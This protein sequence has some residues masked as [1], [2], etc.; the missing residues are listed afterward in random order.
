MPERQPVRD[1]GRPREFDL[2]LVLHRAI[3]VFRQ[4]GY[5][6]TSIADL[7]E[8]MALSRGSLYKAFGDKK[9]VFTAAYDLY[10]SEG[11]A[12]LEA[13]ARDLG[14]GRDRIAA[15]LA[16]YARLSQGTEGLRGC[17]VVATAVELSLHDPEIA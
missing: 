17:L 7:A 3:E 4:R 10:A 8:G 16:L 6:A 11:A 1:R 9:G 12:R 2:Q 15:V 14:S 13:A 5:G